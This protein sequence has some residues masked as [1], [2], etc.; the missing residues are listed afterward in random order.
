MARIA[1][2]RDLLKK[3]WNNGGIM[4]NNGDSHRLFVLT[5]GCS[6]AFRAVA[7]TDQPRKS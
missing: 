7:D 4:G 6:K 5:R 2:W 1:Y 3:D